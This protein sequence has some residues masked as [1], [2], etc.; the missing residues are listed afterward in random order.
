MVMKGVFVHRV[1]VKEIP[2]DQ[3]INRLELR[4]ERAQHSEPIHL[5]QGL[6]R[7]GGQ[8]YLPEM[9]PQQRPAVRV[10]NA[11]RRALRGPSVPHRG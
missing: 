10:G 1:A 6:G 8:E 2:D 5:P 11:A 3:G 4:K 7:P 9:T